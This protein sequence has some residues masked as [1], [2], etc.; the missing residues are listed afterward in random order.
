MQ[1]ADRVTAEA[2]FSVF[3]QDLK[4]GNLRDG[5]ALIG[6]PSQHSHSGSISP[7]N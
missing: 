1:A 2:L 4:Q 5:I 6:V 7:L 3:F